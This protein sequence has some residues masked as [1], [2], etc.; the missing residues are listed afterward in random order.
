MLTQLTRMRAAGEPPSSRAWGNGQAVNRRLKWTALAA[1]LVAT[2]QMI[3][4]AQ[5][6]EPVS[7]ISSL[8]GVKPVLPDM[9]SMMQKVSKF[10]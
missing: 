9:W 3:A 8:V 4:D 7:T 5:V 6:V 2:S 10:R 1:I